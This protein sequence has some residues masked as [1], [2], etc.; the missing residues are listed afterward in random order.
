MNVAIFGGSFDPFH[1]G[2]EKIVDIVLRN[3]KLDKLFIIPT[4]LN[5]FK[6]AFHINANTRLELIKDLYHLHSLVEVINYEVNKKEKTTTFRTII[7]LKSIYSLDKI[8]LVVGAD[9]IK[10]IHLWYNYQNLKTLVTFIVIS[11]GETATI[12]IPKNS[13]LLE[14][15][16]NISSTILK[17]TK[18]I[19]YIP[20][21]IQN[22]IKKLWKIE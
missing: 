10:N 21:K 12:N 7:Y 19:K 3:V 9:N 16:E 20:K 14:L 18:D 4:Y 17:E 22:R 6:N 1:I 13:I 15:N 2:H 8:Y 11:R 5:P